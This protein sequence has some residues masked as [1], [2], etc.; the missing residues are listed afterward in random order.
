MD[1]AFTTL[2]Q[3][4]ILDTAILQQEE[5]YVSHKFYNFDSIILHVYMDTPAAQAATQNGILNTPLY[6]YESPYMAR[7]FATNPT[8]QTL[9]AFAVDTHQ[10]YDELDLELE[11]SQ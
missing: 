2:E 4:D 7:I 5:E 10:L 1:E 9:M 8:H 3:H 11:A 6:L